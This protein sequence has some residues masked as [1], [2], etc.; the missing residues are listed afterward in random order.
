MSESDKNKARKIFLRI[1]KQRLRAQKKAAPEDQRPT[2]FEGIS[3]QDLKNRRE[4]DRFH[5]LRSRILMNPAKIILL[6]FLFVIL[7]G[8][9]LLMLPISSQGRHF[10]SPLTA[11]FTATSASCVTGLILVDTASY[12]S[13]FGQLVILLLIQ[14]GG[15]SLLTLLS[16]F[17]LGMHR[18]MTLSTNLALQDTIGFSKLSASVS[19]VG[20]VIRITLVAE[21]V[22]ACIAIWRF[23]RYMSPGRAIWKGI[24]HAISAFCNA[25]FDLMG[26]VSGPFTSLSCFSNDAWLLLSTAFLIIG[27]GL[28]FLVWMDVIRWP[29]DRRL[30]FHSKLVFG[31]TAFLLS[32]AFLHFYFYE[33]SLPP[34]VQ[35]IA[36]LPPRQRALNAFFQAVTLRTAGFNTVDQASLSAAGKLLSIIYMFIGGGPA[37][38]AGGIKVTT[39]AL[40]LSSVFSDFRHPRGEVIFFRH[41]IRN[42]LIRRALSIFLL[43]MVLLIAVSFLILETLPP[44]IRGEVDLADVL[45]ETSSAFGTV[46]LTAVGTPKLGTVARPLLILLM[47]TGRVGPAAMALS[48]ITRKPMPARQI[49]PE[50]D[51]FVG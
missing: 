19:I 26:D 21:G 42:E 40:L 3:L 1:K 5:R 32:T 46:G 24:F 17:G 10:T 29:R 39:L 2:L 28:G 35:S 34:E 20:K 27:G 12:W 43:G 11:L 18:K 45:F 23:S 47:F 22:G 50:G 4:K 13:F 33:G 44:S 49:F 31:M 36:S 37:S 48:F 15:L 25:G 6:S 9:F 38:T 7:I 16:A 41:R 8:S 51:T 14:I 30:S